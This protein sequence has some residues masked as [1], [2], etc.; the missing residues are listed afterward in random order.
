MNAAGAET[1]TLNEHVVVF[2]EASVAVNV[3]TVVPNGK[4]LPEAKPAV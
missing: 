1:T 2:P 4:L 3:F